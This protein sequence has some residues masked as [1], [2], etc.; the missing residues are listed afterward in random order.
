MDE[1]TFI[2]SPHGT[3]WIIRASIRT[4]ALLRTW[5]GRLCGLIQTDAI[6]VFTNVGSSRTMDGRGL[7]ALLA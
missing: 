1:A 3:L 4:N 5:P 7:E 2:A 6:K